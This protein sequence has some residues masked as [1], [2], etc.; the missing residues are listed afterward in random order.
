[1]LIGIRKWVKS[2]SLD[3]SHMPC[4]LTLLSLTLKAPVTTAADDIHKYF[5]II[6][7]RQLNKNNSLT[8]FLSTFLCSIYETSIQCLLGTSPYSYTTAAGQT[9]QCRPSDVAPVVKD[10]SR[11]YYEVMR[12]SGIIPDIA[13]NLFKKIDYSECDGRF[14]AGFC[15]T[16]FNKK[17]L[18]SVL[19]DGLF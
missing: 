5:F 18:C 15:I 3:S 13:I 8:I 12:A 17:N 7:Q 9:M 2:H 1:M 4:H 11:M 16:N 10:G 6:F 14:I 19:S